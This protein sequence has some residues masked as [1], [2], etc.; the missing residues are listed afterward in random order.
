MNAAP[1]NGATSGEG[2]RV[3]APAIWDRLK[4]KAA[5]LGGVGNQSIM[6]G[7]LHGIALQLDGIDI[8]A[9]LDDKPGT[10]P[11][12]AAGGEVSDAVVRLFSDDPD[13]C[14]Q[15]WIANDQAV[16]DIVLRSNQ[17]QRG[18]YRVDFESLMLEMGVSRG[19][20]EGVPA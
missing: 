10:T 19:A 12:S 13:Q 2:W 1:Q 9:W 5:E 14:A 15:L 6:R 20:E 16:S 8:S 3:L 17:P 11:V 18:A 4:A 7:C